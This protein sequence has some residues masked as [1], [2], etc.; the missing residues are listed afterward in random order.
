MPDMPWLRPLGALTRAAA[1]MPKPFMPSIDEDPAST[2]SEPPAPTPGSA[3]ANAT[4]WRRLRRWRL[5]LGTTGL[6]LAASVF[7]TLSA[8]GPFL[9]STLAGRSASAPSTWFFAA[10]MLV[11]L[12][13][14]HLLLLSLLLVRPVARAQLAIL[15]LAT[16]FAS[17]YMQRYGVVLDPGM[18]RN[19]L[20]TDPVEAGELFGWDMVPHLLLFA[21]LPLLVLSRVR[22]MARPFVRALFVRVAAIVASLLVLV[23]A[24]MLVFQDFSAQM[25]NRKALRYLIT[26]ANLLYSGARV[27]AD[28][29]REAQAARA[30]LGLDAKLDSSW[31]SRTKPILFL[32]VV[33]ETARAA[34]WGLNGY[35][36][37]TTPELARLDVVNFPHVTACGT[38]T[39]T[40]L[41][42]MFAPIGR[43][44]YDEHRIRT[45]ESLLHVLDRAGFQVLWRDNQSGCK[46]VCDGLPQEPVGDATDAVLCADGRCLDEILLRG[47][48]AVARD[49]RG[50]LFVV[51][52]M[53]GNHGPAYYKR[54]PDAY[55]RFTPT[56]DTGELHQCSREQIVNSYDNAL[57]Y[58]D[59]VLAR[60]IAFLRSQETRFDTALLYLSDHGESL[61]EKGLYLHGVPYAIA[62]DEQT[63]VPMVWWLSP[64]HAAGRGLDRSCLDR[65]TTKPW[66]HDNLFHTTMGLLGV[67]SAEYEPPL[68]ITHACRRR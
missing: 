29:T 31:A 46:G 53:L 9:G 43:R 17:Y 64:G 32:L 14:L 16:A 36:R 30:R 61:G 19:V 51:L 7:F 1:A 65:Q 24:L 26:P 68:D 63:Q 57:L 54:H 45:S 47:L 22:L 10:S 3:Q 58:T 42:C 25:R 5:T 4:T 62:P 20:K 27:V 6:A 28:G 59:H 33:G 8:N 2:A 15:V 50:N 66:S 67:L 12:V 56:C 60:A 34:N 13:S 40:S 37:Q 23:L 18:L 48:D 41:P 35:R 11:S 21:V 55:R 52:H 49:A 39:E 44:D 38:N